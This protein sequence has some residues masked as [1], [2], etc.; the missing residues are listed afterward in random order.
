MAV[1]K[2]LV[3]LLNGEFSIEEADGCGGESESENEIGEDDSDNAEGHEGKERVLKSEQNEKGGLPPRLR[4]LL[5]KVPKGWTFRDRWRALEVP[6]NVK[7]LHFG[8]HR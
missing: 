5:L 6:K 8:P 2:L 3:P 4:R 1:E 7:A